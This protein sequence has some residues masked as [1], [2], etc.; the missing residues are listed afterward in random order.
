MTREFLLQIIRENF[1]CVCQQTDDMQADQLKSHLQS[2]ADSANVRKLAD[3]T[4]ELLAFCKSLPCLK[5]ALKSQEGTRIKPGDTFPPLDAEMIRN[6]LISALEE[7]R[8]QKSQEDK[9]KEKK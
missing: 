7:S 8:K 9:K 2:C 3:A 1:E 4:D 5:N 6:K